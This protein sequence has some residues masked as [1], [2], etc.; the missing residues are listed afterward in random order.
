MRVVFGSVN[1]ETVAILAANGVE[2]LTNRRQGCC[3]A[4]HA[5]N[6]YGET[7]R[8]MA[9]ALIDSFF[10]FEGLDAIIVNSAGC[11]S[12]MKDYGDMLADDPA[13]AARARAF[14][15]KV[16]DV[17][18]FLD[19]LG[20]IAPLKPLASAPV[21]ATY[22]D[23]CHLAHGQ[24]I[25]NAPRA[26]LEKIPDLTLAPLAES[27]ICCGSAGIYNI[28]QP[29]MAARLQ[30][31]KI[32]NILATGA[33]LVATANPGC[34]AWIA[35]GLRQGASPIRVAHPVTLLAEALAPPL[36]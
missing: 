18:E 7:A 21:R 12:T 25:R 1:A 14:A 34:L 6:G 10:P 20:W 27:E 15:A 16:R 26:L 36:P 23:A 19:E 29:D 4:L 11:G 28:T 33:T 13:Y 8:D 2:V 31:R 17:S 32:E 5:H 30:R 22:H 3:G 35:A 24:Q 9:R